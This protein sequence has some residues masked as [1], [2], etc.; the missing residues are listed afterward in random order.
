MKACCS[1]GELLEPSSFGAKGDDP[2]GRRS[3]KDC[4]RAASRKSKAAG[5]C[6]AVYLV[7]N[8]MS[9]DAYKMGCS[10]QPRVLR[11]RYGTPILHPRFIIA[12]L[13]PR[14]TCIKTHGETAEKQLKALLKRFHIRG[15]HYQ[16]SD[17]VV[18]IFEKFA[19]SRAANIRYV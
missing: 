11:T 17:Q 5:E 15:E 3:C 19:L 8:G 12:E 16:R 9:N 6:A 14:G 2:H 7:W 1:C 13:L 10:T 4:D 18:R